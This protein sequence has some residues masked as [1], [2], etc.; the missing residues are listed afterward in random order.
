MD[1]DV[2]PA[3]AALLGRVNKLPTLPSVALRVLELG[4]DPYAGIGEITEVVANDPVLSAKLLKAANS[5]LYAMRRQVDNLRQAISVLGFNAALTLA[6]SFSL[7]PESDAGPLDKLAYW[8]RSLL[9]AVGAR[10]IAEQ[11]HINEASKCFVGALLQDIGMLVLEKAH[12]ESYAD[13]LVA[14]DSHEALVLA[15]RQAFGFDH[16]V[17]GAALLENWR[18]PECAWRAVAGSHD[19]TLSSKAAQPSGIACCVYLSGLLSDRWIHSDRVDT[20]DERFAD[21]AH[22]VLGLDQ[23]ACEAVIAHM[24]EVLPHYAGLFEVELVLNED[25]ASYL[26]DEAR[27]V[28]VLR[29]LR[30]L[31][32]ASEYKQRT[33]M[34]ESRNR[35]LEARAYI[36]PL[37]G[38]L[39]RARLNQV[40]EQEFH[41]AI[42][43]GWPLSLGFVDLD[44][45]KRINDTY[46]HQ[47]GDQVLIT[48]SRVL[49]AQVRQAD[50]AARYGGEEFVLVFPGTEEIK[51]FDLLERLRRTVAAEIHRADG[52]DIVVTTSLGLATFSGNLAD[53]EFGTP[54]ELIRAADR[55]LYAAK[56]EGRNRTVIYRRAED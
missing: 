52:A 51:A 8:R 39:N 54:E 27:E 47:I 37:T 18:L 22:V 29:N 4:E 42:A 26:I 28:L 49:Q 31:Q 20:L 3:L 38:L 25:R 12:T 32:E 53:S 23:A 16:A 9:A 46:G 45:F 33:E 36:D 15:E 2:A 44:H 17:V 19:L 55:A 13:M 10:V 1:H 43:G 34:L 7:A 5:P 41:A 24:D 48:V 35:Q 50:I 6:L 56:R 11:A 40:L 30:T 21:Q 14:C